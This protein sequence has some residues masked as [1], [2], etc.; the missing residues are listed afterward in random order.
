L[1]TRRDVLCWRNNNGA[2]YD[3]TRKIFRRPS[4]RHSLRGITDILGFT[5]HGVIIAIEVKTKKG[6]VSKEQKEFIET[7]NKCGGIAFVA[8]SVEDVI[9]GLPRQATG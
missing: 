8:R 3:P 6:I 2:V 9:N 1:L 5:C 4:G 7:V